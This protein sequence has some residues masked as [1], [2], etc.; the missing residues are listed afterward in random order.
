MLKIHEDL[1]LAEEHIARAVAKLNKHH[2][3]RMPN[4]TL[5]VGQ[6]G[7]ARKAVALLLKVRT[8]KDEIKRYDA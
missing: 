1:A 6:I 3:G 5:W 7:E 4:K 2:G 8:L